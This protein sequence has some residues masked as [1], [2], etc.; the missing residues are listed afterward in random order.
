MSASE[1]VCVIFESDVGGHA[2]SRV[3]NKASLRMVIAPDR[4][5]DRL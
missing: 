1:Y 5:P 2:L 3:V 4:I